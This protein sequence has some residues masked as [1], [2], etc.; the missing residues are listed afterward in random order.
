MK[1]INDIFQEELK[2]VDV[3]VIFQEELRKQI[4]ETV[5]K[6]LK[7]AIGPYS[8]FSKALNKAIEEQLKFHPDKLTLPEYSNFVVAQAEVVIKDLMSE[9]RGKVIQKNLRDRLAP[10][11]VNEIEFEVLVDEIR[12]ALLEVIKEEAE[13]R[14]GCSYRIVC[15]EE[16]MTYCS[17]LKL[18]IYEGDSAKASLYMMDS[19]KV[20]HSSG[21]KNFPL[22]TRFASYA[23][24]NTLV[25][26]HE[27]YDK[28]LT[29]EDLY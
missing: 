26:N 17:S 7:D 25:K 27:D 14:T 28:T 18:V 23:F 9:E 20:Y 11:L 16:K 4:A 6:M 12:D 24:N 29:T 13:S 19:G 5:K 15:S 2:N 3:N 1:N 22:A 21:D 10:N 8:T